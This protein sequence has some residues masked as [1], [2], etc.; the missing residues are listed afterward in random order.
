MIIWCQNDAG[1]PVQ[2]KKP[3][4]RIEPG[5]LAEPY[6]LLI[7]CLIQQ[8]GLLFILFFAPE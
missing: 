7:V 5:F 3:D 2:N 4:P 6:L 8:T 1:I